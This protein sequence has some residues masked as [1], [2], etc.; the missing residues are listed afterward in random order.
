MAGNSGSGGCIVSASS[1]VKIVVAFSGQGR[2]NIKDWSDRKMYEYDSRVRLSEV[3]QNRKMTL[4][5]VLN[6]FQDCSTF[7]SEDLGVGVAF[8]EERKRMWVLSSWKIVIYRYPELAEHIKVGTLPYEFGKVTGRRNFR[9][10]DGEG[11]LAACAD[12]LWV[13][14]DMARMRPARVDEEV[15]AAYTLDSGLDMA[16]ESGHI[17]LP[18]ELQAQEAFPVHT[19]QLD[20]NHH[21]N[22]GQYVQLAA[23]YLPEDFQ[24]HEMRAEY[25]KS[26]VLNDVIYPQVGRSEEGYTVLLGN[27]TGKPYAVIEFK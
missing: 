5:A 16:G 3:D 10:M 8:L 7:Q 12:S 15:R 21:V 22:N 13:F 14:M 6:H 24:I 23:D 1:S 27:E 11:R 17:L 25:K 20:V 18:R 4:N 9:L 19:W 2:Y 26:A